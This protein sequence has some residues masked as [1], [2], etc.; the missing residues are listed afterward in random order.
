MERRFTTLICAALMLMGMHVN[1]Q[2]AKTEIDSAARSKFYI[3][4]HVATQGVGLEL[5]YAPVA[6]FNVRVGAS[7]LP[8]KTTGVYSVR[9]EPTDISLKAEFSN[10]H[11]MFDWHPFLKEPSFSR[12]I[13]VTAGA[14]YF[15]KDRGDAV[16]SYRGT[17][18]YGD[19]PISSE[20]LGQ[21]YGSVRW[22]KVAPYLGFGFENAFPSKKF[23]VG[24]AIGTYYM[25]KPDVTLTGTKFLVRNNSNEAQFR[26]NMSYYQFLPVL[27]VN[28]NFSL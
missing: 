18:N 6:A 13:I 27:Q 3:S 26:E 11:A 9:S 2:T 22:N 14:A 10:A 12:K 17:Y 5:K 4:A 7:M 23:N 19:I 21:L 8:F 20:E 1:A 28:F 15:W 24:F 25:G 16:V